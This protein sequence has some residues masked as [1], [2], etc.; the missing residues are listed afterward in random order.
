MVPAIVAVRPPGC[1]PQALEEC[2]RVPQKED[3]VVTNRLRDLAEK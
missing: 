3:V 1:T 2:R